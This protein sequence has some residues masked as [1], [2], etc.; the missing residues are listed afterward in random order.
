MFL[1]VNSLLSLIGESNMT[2]M[3]LQTVPGKCPKGMKTVKAEDHAIWKKY[4]FRK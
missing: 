4:L 3:K 2:L 1:T